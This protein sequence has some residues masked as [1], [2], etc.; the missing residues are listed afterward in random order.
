[1]H[2]PQVTIELHGLAHGGDAVGRLPDGKACFVAFGIPGE[3]VVAE[4]VEHKRRFARAVAVEVVEP[5]PH[6]TTPPCPHFGPGKCGGCRLQ[7][8]TVAHQAEMLRRVVTEQL[9]RIGGF[10]DPPVEPTVR[11]HG[12]DGLGYRNRARLHPDP[13]GRLGFHRAGSHEVEPVAHCP[14]LEPAAQRA[15]D[16]AG[17]EWVGVDAVV[18]RGDANDRSALEVLPGQG[19]VPPLPSGD[20]PAALVGPEGSVALRGDPVLVERV[21]DIELRVSPTSFF[22]ASRAAAGA[23]V[24][25]VAQ[26][27]RV[28]PGAVV[29]DCYAGVGLFATALARAGAVVTAVEGHQAAADDAVA[30]LAAYDATVEPSAVADIV[31]E[32]ERAGRQADVVV[33]DPPRQGAGAE[34]VVRLGGLATRT[35]VYVSCDPAS[36]ARDAAAL[37]EVGWRLTR[38]VPVDQFTH[39]AH[40]ELVGTF[41]RDDT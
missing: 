22:Q 20:L 29:L 41:E 13:T 40:V 26:A 18:V 7:H 3:T 36:F 5:S 39:T 38:V 9:E 15:R 4:V 12:D 30:N 31:A 24:E 10:T 33:L 35:I 6:R 19:G 25:L 34:L 17:D 37:V 28:E 16:E 11:P 2:L 32:W 27:A 21:D 23:L 1:M 8:V 14:L